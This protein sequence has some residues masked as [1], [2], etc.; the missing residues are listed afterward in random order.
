MPSAAFCPLPEHREGAT[1]AWLTNALMALQAQTNGP[2]I[3]RLIEF[4]VQRALL[5]SA[6]SK[7]DLS[8][9]ETSRMSAEDSPAFGIYQDSTTLYTAKKL[10]LAQPQL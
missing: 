1:G 4:R 7:P 6:T 5:A 8:T 9:G 3:V 2:A 10:T